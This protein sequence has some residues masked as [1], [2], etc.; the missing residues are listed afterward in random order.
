MISWIWC[1]GHETSISISILLTES[2]IL[3]FPS[4]LSYSNIKIVTTVSYG[5]REAAPGYSLCFPTN[6]PLPNVTPSWCLHWTPQI[7]TLYWACIEPGMTLLAPAQNSI[8][9]LLQQCESVPHW[10]PG[11]IAHM[12]WVPGLL[13]W[14]KGVYIGK[15]SIM[16]GKSLEILVH[17]RH[18]GQNSE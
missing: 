6:V 9:A 11:T 14:L 13:F 5:A 10:S 16:C 1:W 4:I 17:K 7:F 3:S 15:D 2:P 8:T 18:K 12:I